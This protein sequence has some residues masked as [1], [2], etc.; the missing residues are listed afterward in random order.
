MVNLNTEQ[1]YLEIIE[2]LKSQLLEEQENVSELETEISFLRHKLM[3][4]TAKI[5]IT[6]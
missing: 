4:L 6:S 2:D 1:D 3:L 5:S